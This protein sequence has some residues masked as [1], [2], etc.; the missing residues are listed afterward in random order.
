MFLCV[1]VL[2]EIVLFF[3]SISTWNFSNPIG[4]KELVTLDLDNPPAGYMK[5]CT[6]N[7]SDNNYK[8]KTIYSFS[9]EKYQNIGFCVYS[10]SQKGYFNVHINKD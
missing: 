8:D 7:L 10:N 3:Q 2:G 4:Y 5:I 9:N 1:G 6:I